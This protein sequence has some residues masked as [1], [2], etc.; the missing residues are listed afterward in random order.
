[1]NSRRYISLPA[2]ADELGIH[3]HTLRRWVDQGKVQAI[4]LPSGYRRFTREGLD[5]IKADLGIIPKAMAA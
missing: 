2:A 5:R 1:M 4:V 3:P